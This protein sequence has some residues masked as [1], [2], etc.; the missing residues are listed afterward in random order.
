MSEQNIQ[1]KNM[2]IANDAAES[3]QRVLLTGR[4]RLDMVGVKRVE[5]FDKSRIHLETVLGDFVIKGGNLHIS[6]LL[7]DEERL[8]VCGEIE[9][10]EFG[11]DVG[12]KGGRKKNGGFLNRLTR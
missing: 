2:S 10:L 3:R 8:V 5:D 6:E 7:P 1:E 11:G 9:A 12:K 4:E